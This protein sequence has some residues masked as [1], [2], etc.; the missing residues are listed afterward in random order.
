[1]KKAGAALVKAIT[2]QILAIFMPILYLV[3]CICSFRFG[4]CCGQRCVFAAGMISYFAFPSRDVGV[5]FEI[6]G[7]TSCLNEVLGPVKC[8]PITGC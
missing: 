2:I 5:S 8:I 7:D 3:A 1:M 4:R 6:D